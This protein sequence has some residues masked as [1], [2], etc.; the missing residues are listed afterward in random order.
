MMSV[1]NERGVSS[2]C[3]GRRR[4]GLNLI[5]RL[6]FPGRSSRGLSLPLSWL[7]AIIPWTSILLPEGG[8]LVLVH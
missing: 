7:L 8:S 6:V 1:V 2:H 3:E 4:Q 5:P